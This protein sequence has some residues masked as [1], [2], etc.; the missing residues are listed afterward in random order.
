VRR[1][2]LAT[3]GLAA[4]TAACGNPGAK[5][6]ALADLPIA[7]VL[8]L[9]GGAVLGAVSATVVILAVRQ[10]GDRAWRW[11]RA[12]AAVAGAAP[13]LLAAHALGPALADAIG[14]LP[15]GTHVGRL[16]SALLAGIASA[17]AVRVAWGADLAARRVVTLALLI[18]AGLFGVAEAFGL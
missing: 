6:V 16:A 14:P 15:W 1:S 11:V 12:A 3:T 10:P 8:A 7:L 2:I 18:A 9:A 17:V 5:H 4:A 13:L